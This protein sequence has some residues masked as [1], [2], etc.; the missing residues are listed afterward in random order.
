MVSLVFLSS[1]GGYVS[2][3]LCNN[4]LH[5]RLGQRGIAFVGPI[6]HL[7]AYV[8]ISLHPPYPVLVVLFIFSGFGNGIEDAA[9]NAWASSL[10]NANE[11]LGFLHGF[12]GLGALLSPLAAT[13][14]IAKRGWQ[15]YQFY[16]I[17]VSHSGRA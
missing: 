1:M 8:G 7:V 9:W 4:W 3:A 15:W 5:V 13:S 6:C 16:Y 12:Y 17:L 2:A 11:V 14:L 10:A